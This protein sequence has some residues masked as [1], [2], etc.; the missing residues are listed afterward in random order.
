MFDTNVLRE[1]GNY[2]RYADDDFQRAKTCNLAA[3]IIDNLQRELAEARKAATDD[4]IK[5]VCAARDEVQFALSLD[6]W[7]WVNPYNDPLLDG[8][9]RR[10]D[11]C[12][13]AVRAAMAF[14][15]T[16][17]PEGERGE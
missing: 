13:E 1:V 14:A 10:F 6:R 17:P 12:L 3:D 9:Y 16:N 8:P 7:V 4:V 2:V 11:T 15:T 5:K